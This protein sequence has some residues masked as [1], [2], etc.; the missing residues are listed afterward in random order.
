MKALPKILG[1]A[2][3]ALIV[4]ALGFYFIEVYAPSPANPS[5]TAWRL[6]FGVSLRSKSA[7]RSPGVF[8]L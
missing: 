5:R 8:G 2:V 1:F 6:S 7:E 3:A 4:A